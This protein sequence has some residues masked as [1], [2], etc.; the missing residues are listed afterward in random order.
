MLQVGPLDVS[1]SDPAPTRLRSDPAPT[2]LRPG[3]D[4]TR[5]RPRPA[6]TRLRPDPAPTRPGSDPTRP[7]PTRFGHRVL[8][9]FLKPQLQKLTSQGSLPRSV[10]LP[11]G[12]KQSKAKAKQS[13]AK[14]SKAKAKQNQSKASQS[15]KTTVF[16]AHSKLKRQQPISALAGPRVYRRPPRLRPTNKCLI[17]SVVGPPRTWDAQARYY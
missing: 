1:L 14:Q 9:C 6:P 16:G 10:R 11:R 8:P 7:A 5:L 4:P 12:R 2:R 3:S 15:S 13:K 17:A